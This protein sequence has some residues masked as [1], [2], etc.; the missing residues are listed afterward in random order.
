[1]SCIP[2]KTLIC[3][4]FAR[5]ADPGS[6]T[7]PT[8]FA[9]KLLRVTPELVNCQRNSSIDKKEHLYIYLETKS[10]GMLELL[11]PKMKEIVEEFSAPRGNVSISVRAKEVTLPGFDKVENEELNEKSEKDSSFDAAENFEI[12]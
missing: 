2:Q 12:M 5:V 8:S 4:P 7:H 11:I 10:G 6:K 9:S 1:M 3:T